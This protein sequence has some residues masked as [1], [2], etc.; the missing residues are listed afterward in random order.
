[1]KRFTI[2]KSSF[3]RRA[4]VVAI[5][6]ACAGGALSAQRSEVPT[7][8]QHRPALVRHAHADGSADSTNWSGYAVS[9]ANGAVTSVTGSWVIPAATCSEAGGSTAYASFWVGIDG[10][11]SNSV[12]QTGTD[13]DC[14]SGTPQY[15]AWYEFYP[16]PAYYAGRL[17]SLSPG[18]VMSAT[19]SYANGTF[20]ATIKDVTKNESYT[21]TFTPPAASR[22]YTPPARSSAEWIAEA[23]CCTS[24][25]GILPLAEFGTVSLGEDYTAPSVSTGTNYATIS[26]ISA[27]IGSFG[28]TSATTVWSST[29][30]NENTPPSEETN[31]PAADLMAVPSALTTDGSSFQ[32]VWKSVGP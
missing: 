19:V 18:D 7:S 11:N 9:A 24:R 13:S 16:S 15:Y 12:E 21:A 3:A 17:T 31:P 14:S 28:T 4:M 26:G 32:V 2:A 23:P 27:P 5:A 8:H 6:A 30:I 1:M 10:W 22:R 29:M 20:T 25:G